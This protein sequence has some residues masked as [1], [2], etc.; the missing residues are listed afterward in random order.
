M[1]SVSAVCNSSCICVVMLAKSVHIN[2]VNQ[3]VYQ[4]VCICVGGYF[5]SVSDSLNLNPLPSKW[6][7]G[8]G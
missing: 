3:C 2:H 1:T 5:L 8:G 4:F 7:G 6:G